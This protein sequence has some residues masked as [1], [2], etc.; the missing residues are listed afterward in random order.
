M[1]TV[2]A[3]A[4]AAVAATSADAATYGGGRM[5]I[6]AKHYD[7]HVGATVRTSGSR[8]GLHFE[9]SLK[10]GRGVYAKIVGHRAATARNGRVRLHGRSRLFL[11]PGVLR[12]HWRANLKVG[13][14]AAKG[15]LVI[16]GRRNKGQPRKCAVRPR[17]AF[18]VLRV[19]P[20][21]GPVAAARAG[22]T[23]LGVN[24]TRVRGRFRGAVVVRV[25]RDGRRAEA[26][27]EGAAR[28]RRGP[29]EVFP[30]FT[31]PR[32]IGPGNAFVSRERFTVHYSDAVA[33]YRIL[34]RGRFRSDGVAGTLRLRVRLRWTTKPRFTTRCDSGVRRWSARL[35]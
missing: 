23:Y 31:P 6:A 35:G 28:C 26:A 4:A 21:T 2:A 18:R 27:W 33:R 11:G 22:G 29:R 13:P 10:C 15:V 5:P 32:R 14:D 16:K 8:V 1:T 19:R 12:Y 24:A 34:F 30:N 20:L 9:T 25:T 7:P 3:L 17:R